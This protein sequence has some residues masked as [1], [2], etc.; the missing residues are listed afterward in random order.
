MLLRVLIMK[1]TR[2][3]SLTTMLLLPGACVDYI[4]HDDGW[5]SGICC[6]STS[7]CYEGSL[8]GGVLYW[9]D[10]GVSNEDGTVTCFDGITIPI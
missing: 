5:A 3:A 4:P 1:R 8:C 7:E 2:S 10:D 9:C 6:I